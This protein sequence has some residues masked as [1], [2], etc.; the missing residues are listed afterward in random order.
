MLAVAHQVLVLRGVRV[1]CVSSA[2][3]K[4][5]VQMRQN[6][7]VKDLAFSKPLPLISGGL[8]LWQPMAP[9]P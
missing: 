5:D 1:P 3:K 4:S 8:G 7:F 9:G 2:Q 6:L